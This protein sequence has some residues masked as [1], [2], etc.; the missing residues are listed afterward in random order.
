MHQFN[1]SIFQSTYL[2]SKGGIMRNNQ[3][4]DSWDNSV[5][6]SADGS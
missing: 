5:L 6:V 2:Q 4:T 1:N 3:S